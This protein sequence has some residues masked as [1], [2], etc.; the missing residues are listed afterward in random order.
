MHFMMTAVILPPSEKSR[1]MNFLGLDR[2]I[3]STQLKSFR[4]LASLSGLTSDRETVC[5]SAASGSCFAIATL[6]RE[7]HWPRV[8]T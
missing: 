3:S 1:V 8:E 6:I 5:T 2:G 4:R 7:Y